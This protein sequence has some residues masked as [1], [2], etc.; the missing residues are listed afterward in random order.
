MRNI[1][2]TILDR[3]SV[4]RYERQAIEEEK[5]QL[6]YNA[7][8]TSPTSHNG[9]QF[10]VIAI[11]DQALKEQIYEL[12]H[13]QQIKTCALF[14]VF[15]SDYHKMDV[16]A[17]SKGME[18]PPIQ[19][20][21]DGIL[22]GAVDATIAMSNARIM[23][24]GLGLGCCCIGYIRT[25]APEALSDLLQL[26][27]G[28]AVICGLTIGY[29]RQIPDI[30]PKQEQSLFIH[31]NRYNDEGMVEKFEKYDDQI[32]RHNES[33]TLAAY[34][35]WSD[36]MKDYYEESINKHTMAYFTRQGYGVDKEPGIKE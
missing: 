19:Q 15:C 22:V 32:G 18:L 10:S 17:R 11:E 16:Y 24:E 6:I 36:Q 3:R 2:E 28:V 27:E 1:I 33:H 14:L 13:Q 26:P 30:R 4:R 31:H 20:T 12:T 23:A 25:A 7:I 29:P 9:Q 35:K 5:K 21:L 8:T 34:I